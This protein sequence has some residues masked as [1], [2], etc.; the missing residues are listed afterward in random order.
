MLLT[1]DNEATAR[2]VAGEVGIDEVIA[3]V[4]RV[5]GALERAS[6]HPIARAIA[7]AAQ[8]RLG[9]LPPVEDFKNREGLGVE[10]V[11]DGNAVLVGRPSLMAEWSLRVPPDLDA[12]KQAAE[13]QGR[14]AV[15]AAWDGEVRAV[16]VVADTVKL[17]SAEAVA[18][19]KA[20]GL[21]PVLLTGD[22]EATARAVAGEVGID[23]VIAE[24]L[25]LSL[26]HI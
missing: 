22:N 25:P 4:L 6:E 3:E 17:T 19:L 8:E 7:D 23:E 26:I 2:A 16:L 5:V 11:V 13:S 1:G 18:S 15:L 12:A 21:R 24:V 10:G 9:S 14:T 20:L